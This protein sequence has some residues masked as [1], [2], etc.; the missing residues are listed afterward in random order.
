MK[1]ISSRDEG[2]ARKE[3]KNQAKMACNRQLLK[4]T[5]GDAFYQ[6]TTGRIPGR[7][8]SPKSGEEQN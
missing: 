2:K 7:A 5:K 1:E 3:R 8:T 6:K 4:S